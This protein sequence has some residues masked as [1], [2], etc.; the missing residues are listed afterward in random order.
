M[1]HPDVAIFLQDLGGGGTEKTMVNLMTGL[2]DRGVT[3]DLVLAKAI[4]PFLP[5]VPETVR[6]VDL[7]ARRLL[8]SLPRLVAYLRQAQPKALLSALVHAN[9]GAILSAAVAR[10]DARVVVR[11]DTHYSTHLRTETLAPIRL[12][13]RAAPRLYP[14]ADAV[15]AVSQGVADDLCEHMPLLPER[16]HVIYNPVITDQ[17]LEASRH[18]PQHPWFSE[19][20]PV[21]LGVG[22]LIADK[23]FDKLI[24][25][26]ALLRRQR[27]ARLVILGEG[28]ER[29]HLLSLAREVGVSDDVSLPGFVP[30]PY[31]CMRRAS[32]FV[33]SSRRE[34]LPGA[35][36]EAMACGCPVVSTD[37]PSGP[38]EILDG[39]RYGHL[40]PVG[41][42]YAMA[43]AIQTV[44]SGAA[45]SAD[46]EWLHQFTLENVTSQYLKVL[47]IV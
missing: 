13:M 14:L 33:L 34:G 9:V 21:V 39:G 6:I 35:L 23:A 15:V 47:E 27:E 5:L 29:P 32:V 26:F 10:A 44:L 8:S 18:R 4:G 16:L 31:A 42:S 24:E 19:S 46:A 7:R 12:A 36:I 40:I 22:R 17:L 41:D 38:S 11:E 30:N 45:K 3:V 37:C 43:S 2:V 1:T 28:T 20:V 25:A